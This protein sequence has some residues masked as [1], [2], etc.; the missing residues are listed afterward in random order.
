MDC[1]IQLFLNLF[2]VFDFV[3]GLDFANPLG[4]LAVISSGEN[5]GNRVALPS[6]V[7][8]VV[9]VTLLNQGK[10]AGRRKE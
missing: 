6:N 2:E 1:L 9:H 3:V 10:F 8:H 7:I 4:M 5:V